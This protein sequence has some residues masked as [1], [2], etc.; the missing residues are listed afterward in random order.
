LK[1]SGNYYLIEDKDGEFFSL[2]SNTNSL[3]F[4]RN[5]IKDI[6]HLINSIRGR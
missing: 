4:K 6:A 3:V 5:E 2:G 1:V